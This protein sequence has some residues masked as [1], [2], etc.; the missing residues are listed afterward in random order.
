MKRR[1]TLVINY[2]ILIILAILVLAVILIVFT[3]GFDSIIDK[4]KWI[5]KSIFSLKP[6]GM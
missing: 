1:G 6:E 4:L 5:M 3:K 2:L